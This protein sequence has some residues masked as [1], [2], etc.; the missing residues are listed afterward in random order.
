M[1]LEAGGGRSRLPVALQLDGGISPAARWPTR[2]MAGT[3][4]CA[5]PSATA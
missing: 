4:R 1:L 5:S 3:A 2:P